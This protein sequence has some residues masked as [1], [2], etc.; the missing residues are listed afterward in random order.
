MALRSPI[1]PSRVSGTGVVGGLT[2]AWAQPPWLQPARRPSGLGAALSLAPQLLPGQGR[3]GPRLH[4]GRHLQ[5]TGLGAPTLGGR[6]RPVQVLLETS[7]RGAPQWLQQWPGVADRAGSSPC[8]SLWGTGGAGERGSAFSPR[9]HGG[10]AGPAC[11]DA[12]VTGQAHTE[13]QI[14][15]GALHRQGAGLSVAPGLRA[16]GR[17]APGERTPCGRKLGGSALSAASLPRCCSS[18]GRQTRE[19]PGSGHVFQKRAPSAAPPPPRPS[20][21]HSLPLRDTLPHTP[22]ILC[23]FQSIAEARMGVGME[24]SPGRAVVVGA[25]PGGPGPPGKV[26][27]VAIDVW[28]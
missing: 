1:W 24:A 28:G 26:C 2:V 17:K 19:R 13:A 11:G 7:G 21:G 20:S 4:H 23:L 16:A 27:G 25:V 18:N 14:G 10:G 22:L 5:V 3:P 8:H 9:G 6:G 12:R 15:P